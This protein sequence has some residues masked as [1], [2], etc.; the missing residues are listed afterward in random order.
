MGIFKSRSQFPQKLFLQFGSPV[1][2]MTNEE[3]KQQQPWEEQRLRRMQNRTGLTRSLR[4]KAL[5]A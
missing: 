3:A 1:L 4:L 5:S 2:Q